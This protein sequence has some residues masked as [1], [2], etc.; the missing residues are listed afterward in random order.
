M[1]KEMWDRLIDVEIDV[2][3][4]TNIE[5]QVKQNLSYHYNL[6][7]EEGLSKEEI[8]ARLHDRLIEL[9]K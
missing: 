4:I 9:L 7:K 1:N 5:K 8:T 3:E 2:S 6:W